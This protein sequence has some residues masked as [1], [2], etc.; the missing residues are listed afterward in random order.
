VGVWNWQSRTTPEFDKLH[1]E[2]ASITDTKKRGEKYV[3]M[4][5]LRDESASC[6]RITHGV[7]DFAHAK[8]VTPAILPNGNNW[9]YRYFKEA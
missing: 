4:Q 9:Q 6:V 5:Q 8:S 7:H 3:R 1:Q 2:A